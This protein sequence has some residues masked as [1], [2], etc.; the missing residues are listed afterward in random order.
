MN[1]VEAAA[2]ILRRRR[3]RR[4]A[5]TL[6]GFAQ[7]AWH[8]LE[9]ATPLR[10]GWALDAICDH[11]EGV[12]NGDLIRLLMNV[13]PGTMKSLLT[14]VIWP[15]YEWG[16]RGMRSSRFLGTS[17]KEPLA[18][19]DSLKC[20]RLIQSDWFQRR[21]RV[22]LLADQNA[23]MKFENTDTG[24]REAMAFGSMTG[25]RGDRV[26]LDDPLS[27]DDANSEAELLA[28]ETTFLEALPTRVN[29]DSS[30]IV[31]IMQRL[32]DGDTSGVILSRSLPY[33]HLMIPMRF[34][35][36]RRCY[37]VVRPTQ[38]SPAPETRRYDRMHQRWLSEEDLLE[39]PEEVRVELEREPVR[40]V[41]PQ[42]PRT[43]DGELMF[44]ERFPEPQVEEL[45]RTLG[46]YASAGQLQQRP[47][48]RGGG[49]FKKEWFQP[50][51]AGFLPRGCRMA[52]GWDFAATAD[53]NAA[54]TAA[55]LMARTPRDEYVLVNVQKAR[56][57]PADVERMLRRISQEDERVYGR[58]LRGS[59]P[60]DPGQAGK[61][62]K[63]SLLVGPLAGRNYRASTESGNKVTRAVPLA[64]QAE[65]G[66][67]YYLDGPWVREFVEEAIVFPN[68]KFKDQV[69]AASRAF[70]E[71]VEMPRWYS[72][73]TYAEAYS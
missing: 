69:D 4:E 16:P 72:V 28:A 58:M 8:V 41:Y 15:A 38:W 27:A 32:H 50:Y 49:L 53:V 13:P 2:E 60:Q 68:G 12:T 67:L 36:E 39:E 5:E 54:A 63:T 59:I 56:L 30:A 66:N 26:I 7:Q 22:D 11:L 61:A 9:P 62:Q 24:F 34:E 44:P 31:V 52:R 46:S 48:P 1:R 65:A 33:E 21:W 57:S 70:H 6:R 19:R 37:T 25:S 47:T 20:R 35:E 40:L 55:V 29:N 23:K 14:G 51:P 64:A 71:L 73:D 45:E 10:W 43:V 42:D 3:E 17:H 18:V